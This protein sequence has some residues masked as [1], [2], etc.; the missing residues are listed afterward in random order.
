[1]SDRV[2]ICID[3]KTFYASVECVLRGLDPFKTKLVVADPSRGNGAITLAVSPL[4]KKLGVKNRC[5]IFEI[6]KEIDYI[7]AIPQM[8]KYMEYSS[9]IYSIYLRY[10]AKE[11]IYPY[12]IDEMFLDITTYLSLYNTTPEKL[13]KALMNK[14]YEELGLPSACGI[15]TNL[16]LCKVALDITAKHQPDNIGYLD[17]KTFK[18]TLWNHRPLSD[19]WQIARGIEARLN[20]SGLY[21]MK[22]IASCDEEILYKEF[23]IN[24][25]ILIDHANGIEPVTIK[26]IKNYKNK[27]HSISQ[28]QILFEDYEYHKARLALTEM[29]EVLSLQLVE[30]KLVSNSISLTVGYSKDVHK[31]TGGSMK[32]TICTNVFS[33]LLPYFL[34]LFD[35]TTAKEY[36]IRRLGLSFNNVV[37]ESCEYYDLFTDE[38]EVVKER[39]LERTINDLKKKYGK[40]AVLKGMNLVDGATTVKR[41][42]LI[43][44]HNAERK[45][46]T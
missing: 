27:S 7:V 46:E 16:F 29:V 18:E 13:A 11:D 3:L 37:N 21:T 10:I 2:Y 15:G 24:A 44:G 33:K 34:E 36:K 1:M 38:D 45:D 12:S 23:G 39:T 19:F 31:P 6:P 42:K 25:E 43:G 30:K 20:K 8:K 4:M 40:N 22:D 41:N 5:R 26:D 28:S 32:L 17:E 14:I 35:R 9:K